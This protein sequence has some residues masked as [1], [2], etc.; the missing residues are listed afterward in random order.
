MP[1]VY[2]VKTV[3]DLGQPIPGIFAEL[4]AGRARIGW[5]YRDDLDLRLIQNNIQQGQLLNQ[6]QQEAKRCLGFLTR[7]VPN[8]YL[9][10]PHQPN[11]GEFC[12]V[13]VTGDYDYSTVENS[14]N[15]DFRSFRPC[16]LLTLNPVDMYDQIVSAQLR[17]RLGLQGR[18]Y[19]PSD[20][21]P[22]F[23]FLNAL[24]QAGHIQDDSN[25][26]RLQRI[27]N[28][29]RERLP[30]A[31]Y[32]EFSRAD[33]SRRFCPD[34]FERMGY[35]F[36]VQEG[37]AEAGSD[38][39][40]TLGSPLLP[41]SVEIRIGVQVFAAEGTVEERFLQSKLEQLLQGWE[42]NSLDYGVLLTTG[43]CSENAKEALYRHNENNPDRLVRL[44]DGNDLADLFLKYF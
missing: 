23:T 9:L 24:P 17:Y 14:L 19:E 16:S 26:A 40:V 11:R 10:Y 27:Q 1:R 15:G 22:F 34:L 41:D 42:H 6:A 18:F 33:L 37:P 29:L 38:I 4:Q 43:L 21:R 12:V 8:D 31:L 7:V 36:V 44:I 30:D 13:K 32:R 2:V 35:S 39:V 5:S 20:S 28:D 3:D 25:Y